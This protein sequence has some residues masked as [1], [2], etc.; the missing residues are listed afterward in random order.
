MLVCVFLL[1]NTIVK[2]QQIE[3]LVGKQASKVSIHPQL[4]SG[5][6]LA[7]SSPLQTTK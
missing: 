5:E 7:Y 2:Q 1:V 6:A 3:V 4:G